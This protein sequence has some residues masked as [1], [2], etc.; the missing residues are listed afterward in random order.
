MVRPVKRSAASPEMIGAMVRSAGTSRGWHASDAGTG[1]APS[2]VKTW[3]T[4]TWVL[5][6]CPEL[7]SGDPVG[8]GCTSACR[9]GPGGAT[10]RPGHCGSDSL[11]SNLGQCMVNVH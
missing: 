8:S 3:W 9:A 6:C 11:C 2:G 4:W 1:T 5:P 7:R 10:C